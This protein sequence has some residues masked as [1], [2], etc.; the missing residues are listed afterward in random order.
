MIGGRTFGKV[1]LARLAIGTG[2]RGIDSNFPI[3]QVIHLGHVYSYSNSC[4]Y[5]HTYQ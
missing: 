5:V 3:F 1:E 4:E 2:F